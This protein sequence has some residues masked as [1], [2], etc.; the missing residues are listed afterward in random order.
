MRVDKDAAHRF[1][2]HA[3]PRNQR[4]TTSGEGSTSSRAGP[5]SPRPEIGEV[6]DTSLAGRWR[7]LAKDDETERV[8][9][10]DTEEPDE[11][12]IMVFDDDLQVVAQDE[13]EAF[14]RDFDDEMDGV[15][16]Q[17]ASGPS[18]SDQAGPPEPGV[19]EE[20]AVAADSAVSQVKSG[21]KKNKKNKK[22]K[23]EGGAAA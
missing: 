18:T 15:P 23:R 9:P 20:T 10:G 22:R 2:M 19:P 12:E 14:M 7:F 21:K 3:I 5:S 1:I 17:Q 16:D 13:T 6:G 11:E 8:R 4:M